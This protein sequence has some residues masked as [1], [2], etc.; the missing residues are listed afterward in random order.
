MKD[1][2]IWNLLKK[3]INERE[4][5]P[6]ANQREIWWCS[7]G[8]NVG[9]EEDG[10][11]ELFERP[12]LILKV[13]NEKMVRV[14]PI[15]SKAREDAHHITIQYHERTGSAILSQIKTISTKRLS[16]KLARLGKD[17]FE[18][19]MEKIRDNL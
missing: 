8:V 18:K 2:D 7:L 4:N 10:K 17:Q 9:T 1:F 16:R 6:F 5:T 13:F 12:V 14:A 11:N 15:T 3:N 19:V